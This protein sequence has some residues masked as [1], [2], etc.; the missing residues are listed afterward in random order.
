M[1]RQ[2][3]FA[4]QYSFRLLGVELRKWKL[5]VWRNIPSW[6]QH[7]HTRYADSSAQAV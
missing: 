6:G 2:N 5:L 4:E 7:T 1:S 3:T